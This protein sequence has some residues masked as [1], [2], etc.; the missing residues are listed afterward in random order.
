M[1]TK[2]RA[3]LKVRVL[4]SIVFVL[5]VIGVVG[6]IFKELH[7]MRRDL[8]AVRGDYYAYLEDTETFDE[9]KVDVKILGQKV[10]DVRV[11]DV[12]KY[13]Y[14]D[15]SQDIEYETKK[16][17]VLELEITNNTDHI[18]SYYEDF[19]F[20]DKNGVVSRPVYDIH[21]DDNKNKWASDYGS[22]DLVPG[23]KAVVFIYFED[24]GE[25]IKNLLEVSDSEAVNFV[26]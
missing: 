6:F 16:L 24:N 15:P 1:K 14:T 19:G 2:L 25:E 21:A 8:Y 9:K 22:L 18:Y 3:L 13:N 17:R 11:A 12:S 10:E 23:G 20:A 5:G 7:S 26:Q 4:L